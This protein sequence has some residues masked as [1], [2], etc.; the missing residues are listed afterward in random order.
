MA[1]FISCTTDAFA[2][3]RKKAGEQRVA[4]QNVRRPLRGIQVKPNTY[5]A[6]RVRTAGGATIPLFDSSSPDYDKGTGIGK[7]DNYANFLIQ[8]L[9]ESRAEKQQIIETFGEDYVYFF[10]ERPRFLE[11]TGMLLNTADFNWKSEFWTNYDQHLRGTKLVE[12]NARM[13]FYFDDVVVEGYMLS[14]STVGDSNNPHMLPMQF[15]LYITNYA[16]LSKVGSVFFGTSDNGGSA[17][18]GLIAVPPETTNARLAG[19]SVGAGGLNAFLAK[20][21]SFADD[22]SFSI[23][24]TLEN[25]RNTLYGRQLIVPPG[26]GTMVPATAITNQGN[27]GKPPSGVPIHTMADEYVA[28]TA[29]NILSAQGKMQSAAERARVQA[30]LELDGPEALDAR[31][32]IEF[33]KAGIDTG[34]QSAMMALLGR[35]AFAA[36]QFAAPFALAKI[37]GGKIG[38]ADQASSLLM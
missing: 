25:L 27:F 36:V 37:G 32:R 19:A 12:K 8:N 10:G 13:Y 9:R 18:Q 6:I 15:Q 30:L 4:Q 31:A 7:S 14:A 33:Q 23:Q 29:D 35:G 1:V 17:S 11:V 26:I 24:R 28:R 38:Q 22:A 16:I 20:T 3:T 34:S 5:A 21:A 2:E